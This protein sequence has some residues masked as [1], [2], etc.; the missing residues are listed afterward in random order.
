MVEDRGV[1]GN[2][3]QPKESQLVTLVTPCPVGT[4]GRVRYLTRVSTLFIDSMPYDTTQVADRLLLDR[5]AKGEADALR[6]LYQRHGNTM[7]ALAYRILVDAGDAEEVVADTF[8]HIWRAAA[9][10]LAT[11]NQSVSTW[12]KDVARSRAR[13]LLLAREWPERSGPAASQGAHITMIE[14]VG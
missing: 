12:L 5:M 13:A 4:S 9:R 8:S 11:T 14:E 7:Y 3:S 10:V 1:A 2:Q 6:A